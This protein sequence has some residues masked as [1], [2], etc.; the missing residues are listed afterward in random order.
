[1]AEETLLEV[2]EPRSRTD[3][4]SLLRSFAD[5]LE[6]EGPIEVA[7]ADER[8]TVTPA[9]PSE[10]ELE[11]ER[12]RDEDDAAG[13][14]SEYSVEFELEWTET[15]DVDGATAS[16]DAARPSDAAESGDTSEPGDATE[17]SGE[18][19]GPTPETVGGAEP[20]DP[21]EVGEAT[22]F[23]EAGATRE[24]DV[25]GEAGPTEAAG[26]TRSEAGAESLGTFEVFRDSA[27]EWRWRLVHRNGN[28]IAASGEGYTRRHNAEKGMRSVMKNAP[29][30][31][32]TRE[33]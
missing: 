28:V 2:E 8:V 30:A 14:T 20:D 27:G 22:E 12:T 19:A 4:A 26:E 18:T 16:S 3:I 13:P 33:K 11:I 17:Q 7:E 15:D 23:G 9:D 29:G 32:V 25:P 21:T 1:M 24:A 6:G 10:F 5:Q 31:E